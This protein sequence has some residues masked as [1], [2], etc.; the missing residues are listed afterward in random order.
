MYLYQ[1]VHV[2]LR[3]QFIYEQQEISQTDPRYLRG[4]PDLAFLLAHSDPEKHTI[5]ADGTFRFDADFP[6]AVLPSN[7]IPI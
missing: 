6:V 2:M 5:Q 1:D 4:K 3:T 7:R